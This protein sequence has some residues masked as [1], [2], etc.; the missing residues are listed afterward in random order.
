MSNKSTAVDAPGTSLDGRGVWRLLCLFFGGI[1]VV[2]GFFAYEAL[3][4]YTGEVS[5]EP[6]SQGLAYNDRIAAS[7]RQ[8][9]LEWRDVVQVER[10]G[11][12]SV[13]INDA[14]GA[15]VA[16]L[17]VRAELGRPSTDRDDRHLRFKTGELGHYVAETPALPPGTWIVTV[18]AAKSGDPEHPIY[19]SRRRV[20]LTP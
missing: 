2:N 3:S 13:S 14:S 5:S 7:E 9:L 18:E 19:R 17:D 11:R 4:T 8:S 15:A 12:V 1:F 10:S 6:F 16:G 20:W